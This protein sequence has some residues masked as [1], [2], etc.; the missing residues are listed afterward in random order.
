[1]VVSLYV[2]DMLVTGS[3]IQMLATFKKEME[4]VFEM[5]D[6]GTMNYFLGIEI[7]QCSCNNAF[8]H[9]DLYKEVYMK[10][11]DGLSSPPNHVCRLKK[12]L[13]GLKQASRQWFA[14]LLHELQIQGFTQSKCDY[15][16][17]I[18]QS[19]DQITIASIYVDDIILTG[20]DL[21]LINSLKA[22][23]HKVFSIKDLG[24]LYLFLGIE[25]GYMTD[26]ITLSQ[27][28]FTR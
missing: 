17:F 10:L 20:N 28:K 25:V 11:P 8:L 23:L 19:S 26:G 14:K 12:S 24:K 16:L 1:M 2:D 4:D 21:S 13:Y 6:L 9:G 18:R 7:K 27:G 5:S 22:H 15:S 3:N